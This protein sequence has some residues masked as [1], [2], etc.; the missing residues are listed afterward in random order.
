MNE[1]FELLDGL[2]RAKACELLGLKSIAAEVI[3]RDGYIIEKRDIELTAL[4]I[5]SKDR[6]DVSALSNWERFMNIFDLVKNGSPI[7]PI[8]VTEGNSGLALS[9][10]PL[11]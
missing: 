9:E 2:R 8:T 5:P 4:R 6:I 10:I 3:D 7:S 1:T 11:D